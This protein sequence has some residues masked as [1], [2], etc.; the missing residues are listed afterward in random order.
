MMMEYIVYNNRCLGVLLCHFNRS[1]EEGLSYLIMSMRDPIEHY[2]Y[3]TLIAQVFEHKRG[4]YIQASQYYC[5]NTI[6]RQLFM[7]RHPDIAMP[8]VIQC[9]P[10]YSYSS[11]EKAIIRGY[12]GNT[13]DPENDYIH[14]M[15]GS[16]DRSHHQ[17]GSIAQF[18]YAWS[19]MKQGRKVKAEKHLRLALALDAGYSEA[20]YWL[21][22]LLLKDNFEDS[23]E[24]LS[25]YEAVLSVN[26]DHCGALRHQNDIMHLRHLIPIAR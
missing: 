9:E 10:N 13:V 15:S 11:L 24:S 22:F 8:K 23:Q 4:D 18:E 3:S 16:N 25:H 6:F 17:D 20:H 21:G 5:Y 26:I 19:M 12:P 1:C 2:N 7:E 14:A